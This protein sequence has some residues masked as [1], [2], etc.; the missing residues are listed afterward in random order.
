MFAAVAEALIYST[1][2]SALRTLAWHFGSS[3]SFSHIPIHKPP[4]PYAPPSSG[5]VLLWPRCVSKQSGCEMAEIC[6]Q[7]S[8][9]PLPP[10]L[11][12][13]TAYVP[14]YTTRGRDKAGILASLNSSLKRERKEGV[15][16]SLPS[17]ILNRFLEI[18]CCRGLLQTRCSLGNPFC[19]LSR[20]LGMTLLLFDKVHA[21]LWVSETLVWGMSWEVCPQGSFSCGLRFQDTDCLFN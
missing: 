14:L 13:S 2:S 3:L 11:S 15:S 20:A 4:D 1:F 9:L 17:H 18:L 8:L 19:T 16:L 7:H 6:R 21:Q 10:L 5:N 12:V